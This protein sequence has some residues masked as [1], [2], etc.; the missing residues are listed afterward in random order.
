MHTA[1]VIVLCVAAAAAAGFLLGG[2][3]ALL[4]HD[5]ADL[6]RFEDKVAEA[7]RVGPWEAYFTMRR[8]ALRLS[9]VVSHWRTRAEVRRSIW[10]GLASG[11]V[12]V[13]AA[14]CL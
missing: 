6:R 13:I 5:D 2:F 9:D 4:A 3:C 10:I 1:A 12:A 14:L 7:K 11:A 8:E